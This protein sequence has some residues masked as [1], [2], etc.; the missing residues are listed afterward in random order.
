[1]N[2]INTISKKALI[3]AMIAATGIPTSMAAAQFQV[4]YSAKADATKVAADEDKKTVMVYTDHD[5]E[6]VY[7]IK[8]VDGVVKHASLDGEDH[9]FVEI[10][11]GV[12]VF[13]SDDGKTVHEIKMHKMPGAPHAPHAQGSW[14]SSS[15]GNFEFK[16][17]NNVFFATSVGPEDVAFIT[18]GEVYAPKVML[19]INLGEPSQILRKH[20]NLK[21][22]VHAILVEKVIEGLPAAKAGLEE[23]DVIVSID[24]SDQANGEILG[25]FLSEK[26]AGDSMKLVVL[27]G[28]EKI[29]LK[30]SLAEYDAQALGAGNLK[31]EMSAD[32]DDHN[33]DHESFEIDFFNQLEEGEFGNVQEIHLEKLR[34]ELHRQLE[35]S[36]IQNEMI[37]KLQ[38]KAME[39]MK[40]AE[41]QIVELRD[42]KLFVRSAEDLDRQL[43]ELTGKL[44]E[45]FPEANPEAL[46]GHLQEVDERLSKLE[47]RLNRQ[48]EHMGAQME[49]LS[50]MFERLMESLEDRD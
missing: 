21:D 45:R 41:R 27:R 17:D 13:L 50:A 16:G 15:D 35:K 19:G 43:H 4:E 32:E 24:G 34:E 29:K 31:F 8:I 37:V 1:M 48:M 2:I 42:G 5:N 18:E 22:G 9:E 28:G 40:G 14:R 46:H 36:N 10:K 49:R 7:K 39:A 44:H 26:E 11:D 23:F 47:E 20:L 25:K 38:G 3:T 30:V 6:H 12:I 33:H